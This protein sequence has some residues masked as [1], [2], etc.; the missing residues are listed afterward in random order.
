MRTQGEIAATWCTCIAILLGWIGVVAALLVNEPNRLLDFCIVT[1][2]GGLALGAMITAASLTMA[3]VARTGYE[4]TESL[5]RLVQGAIEH[6]ADASRAH[7]FGALGEPPLAYRILAHPRTWRAAGAV[8]LS[9]E[10]VCI[11][12]VCLAARRITLY[13]V[14]QQ[15]ALT[16]IVTGVA[17]TCASVYISGARQ[18][19]VVVAV[20]T[21]AEVDLQLKELLQPAVAAPRALR[22]VP[23][24]DDGTVGGRRHHL[25]RTAGD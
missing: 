2:C 1:Q 11:T 16:A 14:G 15:F 6:Q 24:Q 21:A 22:S 19:R 9:A 8:A 20:R 12:N 7:L 23:L 4:V 13:P 18:Q 17:V 25:R 5:C 10:A 3:S